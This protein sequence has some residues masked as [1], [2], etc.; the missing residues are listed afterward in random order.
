M[1][2][3]IYDLPQRLLSHGLDIWYGF[4][5]SIYKKKKKK[6]STLKECKQPNLLEHF[7]EEVNP[8]H[9]GRLVSTVIMG[10]KEV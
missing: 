8:E 4:L 6:D 1:L 3:F 9:L 10:F 2:S 5:F 7:I